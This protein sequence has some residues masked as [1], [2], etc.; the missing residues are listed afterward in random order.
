LGGPQRQQRTG[1]TFAKVGLPDRDLRRYQAELEVQNK[2]LRFSQVA[3][4]N[5]YERFVA[6][7]SHV[8]LALMVVAEDGQILQHNAQALAL[9]QPHESDPPLTYLLPLFDAPNLDRIMEGLDKARQG[10]TATLTELS[11]RSG[12]TEHVPIDL[13]LAL[14]EGASDEVAQFICAVVDQSAQKKLQW[15]LRESQKMQAIDTMAGGIAHDFN[16]IVGAILG[17]VELAQQDLQ[18]DPGAVVTSLEEITKA[19]RRARDLVR[20]ILAFSRN[21]PARRLPLQLADVVRETL[22]LFRIALPP[23][24]ELKVELDPGT[25]PVLADAT[26]MEQVLLNL[27]HNAIDAI[28]TLPGHVNI[29]LTSDPDVTPGDDGKELVATGSTSVCLR[30]SDTGSG[31][32]QPTLERIFEPFFTTKPVGQGTGLGLSVVHGIVHTHD[33]KVLVRSA[34]G[35]GTTFSLH[36]PAHAASLPSQHKID[37]PISRTPGTGQRV[38]YIDDDEALIFLVQRLLTRK[39]YTVLTFSDSQAALASLRHNPSQCDLL[40]TDFNMPGVSG[41]DVLRA[42]RSICPNMPMALASGHVTPDIERQA[43]AAG[44]R[45]LIYKPNDVDEFC[46]TVQKLL[47]DALVH[48]RGR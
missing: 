11:I 15:Q 28:G 1:A 23:S 14:I 19:G 39:G 43:M 35:A 45:A 29:S 4:E 37:K 13:H 22:R 42:A 7:F 17:N 32:D 25:P 30:V 8:P 31:M 40:V 26:Q 18:D 24:I 34:P 2:A 27:L 36:F 6:L 48:A 38:M 9:L 33:G 21:E 5:A 12:V 41:V 44:A 46:A 20:Q 47:D 10:G 16:N 3:A